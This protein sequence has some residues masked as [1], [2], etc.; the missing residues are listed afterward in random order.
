MTL[1]NKLKTKKKKNLN[2]DNLNLNIDNLLKSINRNTTRL[3]DLLR[4]ISC[5]ELIL[6]IH[7]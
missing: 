5:S 1:S 4:Y 6:T 2:S 7:N 3:K